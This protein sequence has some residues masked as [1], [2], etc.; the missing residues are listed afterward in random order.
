MI[1]VWAGASL[2]PVQKHIKTRHKISGKI[3]GVVNSY[4]TFSL[5]QCPNEFEVIAYS[6]DKEIEAI[7]HRYLP[8]EGWM[9]HPE[10]ENFFLDRDINQIK[11]LFNNKSK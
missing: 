9:W 8:W 7:R 5:A 6:E 4:H 11:S 2:H 3:M 10:R 1:G